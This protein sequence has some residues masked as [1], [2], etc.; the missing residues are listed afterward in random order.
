MKDISEKD[1]YSRLLATHNALSH[2]K[3]ETSH[4]RHNFE[5][6]FRSVGDPFIH[7]LSAILCSKSY[8]RMSGKNQVASA[9]F[10]PHVRNRMTHVSEVVA[11]SIRTA[12]HLGLNTNL[13]Q[14]ISAGHDIG[15]V[16]FGHQGEHYLQT[17]IG[18]GFCHELMGVIVAQHIERGGVGLNLTHATL[19]G[20]YRHSGK[21]TS[22]SMTPEA[23]VN[24]Y[25]DKIAY[26]FA[27]Y[28]DFI[29]MQWHCAP[30]LVETMEWFGHNQRSR[31]IRTMLALCEESAES[32]RVIFENSEPAQKFNHLR[33]LMYRE[34]ERVV[35]Q[36]VSARLDPIYEILERSGAIPAWLG[37]ALLTDEEVCRLNSEHRMM[38]WKSLMDTGLGEIL[39]KTTPEKLFSIDPMNLDLD[40]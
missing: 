31:T 21:N 20:M 36:D 15:H 1:L 19:D 12:S 29:R 24:R 23:W 30:E 6:D 2:L 17:R 11:H 13:V 39:R 37:I 34:Y 38:N 33:S 28:N 14:A 5:N 32:G 4:R 18:K 10:L 26:L 35:E 3:T 25:A 16:P 27:D 22:E 8:R 40:W 7:D 9:P